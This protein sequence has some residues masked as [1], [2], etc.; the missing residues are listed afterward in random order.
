MTCIKFFLK[1]SIKSLFTWSSFH[2][3]NLLDLPPELLLKIV[4]P[5][6]NLPL[7]VSKRW[8]AIID[9]D[10][11]W[12]Q[13]T[14]FTVYQRLSQQTREKRLLSMGYQRP[15]RQ[16]YFELCRATLEFFCPPSVI[17]Q[18]LQASS[19]DHELQNINQTL[20]LS[21]STFWSSR[22]TTDRMN[23]E[24]LDYEL[25]GDCIVT[26]IHIKPFLA[27]YQRNL[28]TYAPLSVSFSISD[29]PEFT[30]RNKQKPYNI[31]NVPV[32]QEFKLE[33]CLVGKYLRIYFVGHAN[34]QPST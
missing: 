25:V 31:E 17:Q 16:H 32:L 12:F 13:R 21:Q 2:H 11:Y 7:H 5:I 1:V 28:P 4:A 29:T 33:P 10:S 30:T 34:T 18:P 24:Y 3:M 9:Q 22:G 20:S 19:F 26:S 6:P 23:V 14:R 8:N 15:Y 27:P